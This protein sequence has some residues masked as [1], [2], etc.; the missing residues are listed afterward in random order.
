MSPPFCNSVTYLATGSSSRISP[1][2]T[3]SA[4]QHGR[5]QLAD[6]GQIEDRIGR[7]PSL[8]GGVGHAVV[9]ERGFAVRAQRHCNSARVIVGQQLLHVATDGLLEVAGGLGVPNRRTNAGR[10]AGGDQEAARK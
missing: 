8:P 4:K 10:E 1:R 2:L 6:R 5:K 9:V 3:A 7:D